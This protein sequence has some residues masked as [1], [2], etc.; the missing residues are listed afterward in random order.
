MLNKITIMGR[1]TKEPELR[2][3]QSGKSVASFTV[4]VDRDFDRNTTDFFSCVAWGNTAEFVSKYFH[5]GTLAVVAGEM[6]S[7][8]WTDKDGSN[9]TSWNV[10]VSNIYFGESKKTTDVFAELDDGEEVPF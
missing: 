6:Q 7:Q 2:K 4:A 9:H 3:T 10:N 5:K 8:H 1:L